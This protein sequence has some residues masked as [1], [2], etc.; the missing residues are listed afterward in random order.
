MA[1]GCSSPNAIR[2]VDLAISG[3]GLDWPCVPCRPWISRQA[4]WSTLSQLKYLPSGRTTGVSTSHN[5]E[6]ELSVRALIWSANRGTPRSSCI[7]QLR[8]YQ[9][10]LVA[11][12]RHLDCKTCNF[13]IWERAADLHA[14]Y[15]YSIRGRNS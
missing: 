8:A 5:L 10:T 11:R 2:F 7:Y 3:V 1:F 4:T 15:A 9:G 6:S 13:R 12:R 14:D